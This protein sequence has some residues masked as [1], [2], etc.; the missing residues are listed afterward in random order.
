MVRKNFPPILKDNEETYFKYLEGVINSVDELASVQVD[1]TL[2]S[3]AFRIAPSVPMYSQPLLQE[4]I[5]YHSFL[6]IQLDLSKS[7][8]A[9]STIFFQID[10]GFN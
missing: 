5:K 6:G 7:I 8:K 9:N 10:L 1:R 2:H 4:L 3:Y